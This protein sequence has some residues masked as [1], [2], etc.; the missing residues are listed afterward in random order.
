MDDIGVID[1]FLNI[2]TQYIDNGFGLLGGEVG[3]LTGILI[4]IDIT[5]VGLLW[6]WGDS[7]DIIAKFIRKVLYIGAFA[8]ILNNFNELSSIIF[9]SFAGLGLTATGTGLTAGELLRPGM[10]AATGID[11]GRPILDRIDDLAGFPDVFT[12]LGTILVLLFSWILIILSFFILAIQLFVTLIEFKLT[13]LAGF[14]LVPF[15]LW[16]KT[17]FLAEKVL[18]NVVSAGVK[19]LVLAVIV[20]IGTTVFGEFTAAPIGEFSV[21][22]ALAILLASLAMLGLGMFGPG[23]AT[24]LVSGAPQ[25]GAGSAASAMLVAGGL[26]VGSAAAVIRGAQ[27]VFGGGKGGSPS[28]S[29][30]PGG[31]PP[32]DSSPPPGG[33]GPSAA[34]AGGGGAAAAPSWAQNMKRR[35]QAAHA[36]TTSANALRSTDHGASGPSPDLSKEK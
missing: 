26:A 22:H 27:G 9:R 13:T 18:G 24:G 28:A 11:A 1:R 12:N 20:G 17:A 2:F 5:L 23:I 16:N 10:L 31:S 6:A 4:A 7:E 25:L 32:A 19:V 29:A 3:F 21:N 14:V 15:A 33:T 34:P 36:L 8:F 35:G 30:T